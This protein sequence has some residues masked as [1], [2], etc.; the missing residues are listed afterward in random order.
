MH[1]VALMT[2]FILAGAY[3]SGIT[4]PSLNKEGRSQREHEAWATAKWI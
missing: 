3:H 1:K 2:N 4:T